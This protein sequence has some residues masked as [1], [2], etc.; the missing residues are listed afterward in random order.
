MRLRDK[1][2]EELLDLEEEIKTDIQIS[3]HGSYYELIDLYKTLYRRISSD[4]ESEYRSSLFHIKGQ[5]VYHLVTHGTYLK[6]VHQKD[7]RN[8][9]KCLQEALKYDHKLP[10]AHYRLGFLAYKNGRHSVALLHFEQAVKYKKEQVNKIFQLNEQQM[11]NAHLYL[12]NCGLFLAQQ[13]QDSLRSL[14]KGDELPLPYEMSPYYPMIAGTEEYLVGHEYCKV[15]K[16]GE[17]YIG[18]DACEAYKDDLNTLILDFT[19]RTVTLTWNS[20]TTSLA[21]NQAEII[22]HFLLKS[23]EENPLP[24]QS[25]FDL[26]TASDASGEVPRNTYIQAVGRLR[27]KFAEIGLADV[28]PNRNVGGETAYYYAGPFPYII[29]HRSD[30][31]FLLR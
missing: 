19:D 27:R 24:R 29:L 18:K 7:D 2:I 3:D 9:K 15:T 14:G 23:C 4:R 25:F 13:A 20:R 5:L 16:E 10:I 21:G 28:L 8:A 26:F 22:R 12:L 6:T 17:D 31:V 1:T 30:D 11:Y